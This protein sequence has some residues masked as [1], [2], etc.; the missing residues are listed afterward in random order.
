MGEAVKSPKLKMSLLVIVAVV[1]FV[2]RAWAAG[3][4]SYDWTGWYIG[5][6]LGYGWVNADTVDSPLYNGLP[7]HDTVIPSSL[8]PNPEGVTGG[9]QFGY[10]L[11]R[12][13]FV[14]GIE[15]DLSASA[16]SGTSTAAPINLD[17]ASIPGSQIMSHEDISWYGT[18]RPRLGYTVTPLLLL[19]GTGGLAYGHANYTATEAYPTNQFLG[20]V[21]NTKVGWTAGGGVEYAIGK[22][23]SLKAEYLYVDLGSQSVLVDSVPPNPPYQ[24]KWEWNTAFHVVSIGMNI[25]F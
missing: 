5:A 9:G 22:R 19:Y 12:G 7:G 18:L 11:Q 8:H 21:S 17:G 15:A 13:C 1:I 24:S 23:W 25:K 4:L 16:M 3:T 10:N 2:Q 14:F 20:S 6:H